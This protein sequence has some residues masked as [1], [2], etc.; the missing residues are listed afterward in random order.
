MGQKITA[1][2]AS[3]I[4]SSADYKKKEGYLVLRMRLEEKRE[5]FNRFVTRNSSGRVKA[6]EG[7]PVSRKRS[8]RENHAL[9]AFP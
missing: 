1:W 6:I 5:K 9:R 3:K 2:F 7:L 8:L 4:A